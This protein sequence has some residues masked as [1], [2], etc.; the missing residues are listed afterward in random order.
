MI[1]TRKKKIINDPVYGFVNIPSELIY[2]LIQHPWFQRL[3]RIS[4]LGLSSMVYPG[5]NHNRFSHALGAMHLMSTAMEALRTKGH[6][7]PKEDREAAMMAILL[8]DIGHG[9]FSHAL[10]HSILHGVHHEDLSLL[11]MEKLNEQFDGVLKKA[12]KIFTNT[13][14]V[15]FFHQLVSS[16]LDMDRLDYLQRDCFFTGVIEGSIGTDRIIRMLDIVDNQIVVE[17]KGIYSI[18][19]FLT[20]RRLMYWQVYLHKTAVAAEE[21]LVQLIRRARDLQDQGV[22]L[23]ATPALSLFLREQVRLKDFVND[24]QYLD[25]YTALDDSDIF[26]SVKWWRNH[27]D[28][29]ISTLS[30]MLLN[31]DVYKIKFSDT[32]FTQQEIDQVKTL[33]VEKGYQEEELPYFCVTG[34]VSNAAYVPYSESIN[35]KRKDGSV[36]DIAQASD[37]PNVEALSKIVKKYYLC[38]PKIISL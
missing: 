27:E 16:Q 14:K 12:I 20:A 10:E 35:I 2:D 4:Q 33:L 28:R 7:I 22:S 5:A 21:V 38:Y 19:N 24:D 26:A 17:E 30:N 13:Y 9:P 37:L 34:V 8:H 29:V 18:E 25:N 1:Q 11:M 23:M 32:P 15:P 36:V 3:R 6:K 31:R